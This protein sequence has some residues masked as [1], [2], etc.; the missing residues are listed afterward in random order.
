MCYPRVVIVDHDNE[1]LRKS[2]PSATN[3]TRVVQSTRCK[4]ENANPE[5]PYATVEASSMLYLRDF[6]LERET[7]NDTQKNDK[8]HW[9][10]IFD[11]NTI[12]IGEHRFRI[13]LC[14]A[15]F[16]ETLH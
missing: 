11:L 3:V 2:Q 13:S 12:P 16:N 1:R 7:E 15:S 6:V 4:D 10:Q 14:M 5:P 8:F 9:R